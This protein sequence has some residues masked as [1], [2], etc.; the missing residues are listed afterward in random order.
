MI[1]GGLDAATVNLP[2]IPLTRQTSFLGRR[3]VA[4]GCA[5]KLE[6]A[7]LHMAATGAAWVVLPQRLAR[8][9][10]FGWLGVPL[11]SRVHPYYCTLVLSPCRLFL[12]LLAAL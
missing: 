9:L 7:V 6:P 5:A 12:L 4:Q 11:P 10:T 3:W 8:V 2:A 1:Y